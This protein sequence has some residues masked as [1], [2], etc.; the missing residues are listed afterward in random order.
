MIKIAMG[1]SDFALPAPRRG[2]IDSQ[3]GLGRGPEIG[4]EIHQEIQAARTKEFSNYQAEVFVTHEFPIRDY[5]LELRGRMDGVFAGITAG[6]AAGAEPKIEEIKSTFNIY[7]LQRKFRD[8]GDEHPY[9]LQLKTYGYIYW[10]QNR[11]VPKLILHLVSSRNRE[12][13]DYELKLDV[14]KFE[15][16]L[17]IRLEEVAQDADLELKRIARRKKAVGKFAFPFAKPRTGQVE[18]IETIRQGMLE[19]RPMLLQAPTGL[20]KTVGVLYP[21]LQEALT[22]GQRVIYATPKNSQH[23]VAEEAI[24]KLQAAGGKLKSLTITAKSKMCFKNEAIC[25]PDYCE[26]AK[27]HY[28]KVADHKIADQL[29]SKRKL[30]AQSFKKIAQKYEVCPFEIQLDAAV[31][32]DTIICDYNYVFATNTAFGS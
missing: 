3:S 24:E 23:A 10:L 1:V 29:R 19:D 8:A 22:R 20:G 9:C 16:Y 2:S 5:V 6:A 4:L 31:D 25:N 18:L 21:A 15:A 27:D 12:S 32:A 7:D 11:V 17:Q 14:E 13:L 30:T 26:F 28:K